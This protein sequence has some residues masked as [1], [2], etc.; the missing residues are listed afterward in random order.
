MLLPLDLAVLAW[1]ESYLSPEL[2]IGWRLGRYA[3]EFFDGLEQVRIAATGHNSTIA[4]LQRQA[5][6]PEPGLVTKP[7]GTRPW[8][9]LFYHEPT[10]TALKVVCIRNRIFPAQAL[11]S[12]EECLNTGSVDVRKRY[13]E[14][15]NAM[16]QT[17]ISADIT[18]LCFLALIR[19][20][21]LI[22]AEGQ[23]IP[24]CP[25]CRQAGP[26]MLLEVDGRICCP[27]CAGLEPSWHGQISGGE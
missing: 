13:Q 8:D 6:F 26:A 18:H 24:A 4:A 17:I 5:R 19:C 15:V 1:K 23:S 3:H 22:T 2:A 20:R 12:L 21:P 27:E 10:A 25:W 14:G 11:R 9:M 16:V 7:L